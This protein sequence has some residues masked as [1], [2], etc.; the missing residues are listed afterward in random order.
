MVAATIL[1]GL[2]LPLKRWNAVL[3]DE[4]NRLSLSR[5]QLVLWT[6]VILSLIAGLIIARLIDPSE[7]PSAALAFSIPGELWAVLGI[8]TGSAA[9]AAVVSSTKDNHRP[10]SMSRPDVPSVGNLVT[11]EEGQGADVVIDVGKFQNLW[12]SLLLIGAYG[13]QTVVAFNNAAS[14]DGIDALPGYS[15]GFLALLAI[16]HAGYLAI[17][18][19]DQAGKP[20][21]PTLEEHQRRARP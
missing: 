17:K 21:G 18:I 4:R 2:R 5:L 3:V 7:P 11:V 6:L 19:P 16:S 14:P 1:I 20:G 13:A 15:N 10:E 8:S 9:A 12:F